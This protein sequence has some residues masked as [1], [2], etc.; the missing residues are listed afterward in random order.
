MKNM[1]ERA[2]ILCRKSTLNFSQVLDELLIF[3]DNEFP[4]LTESEKIC[5]TKE[6]ELKELNKS[7]ILKALSATNWKISGARG[8]AELL[9]VKDNTLWQRI[10][11]LGLEKPK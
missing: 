3:L 11:K 9:G 1:M 6:G 10:K 5:I 8:A 2:V 7:N 4:Q